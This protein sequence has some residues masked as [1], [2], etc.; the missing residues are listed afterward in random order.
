MIVKDQSGQFKVKV[1]MK[2]LNLVSQQHNQEEAV[3]KSEAGDFRPYSTIHENL[4]VHNF[5]QEPLIISKKA[6]H[7]FRNVEKV[8]NLV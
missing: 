4:D 7:D 3:E 8:V 5:T 6:V 2:K 1:G